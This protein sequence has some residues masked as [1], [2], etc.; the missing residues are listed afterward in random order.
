LISKFFLKKIHLWANP[1]E[2]NQGVR[3]S[4]LSLL[5][6]TDFSFFGTDFTDYTDFSFLFAEKLHARKMNHS[7]SLQ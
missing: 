7:L 3:L 6:I 1:H 2:K 5:R 4:L